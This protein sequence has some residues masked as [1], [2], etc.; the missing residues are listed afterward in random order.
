MYLQP[1]YSRGKASFSFIGS[2]L[3][4]DSVASVGEKRSHIMSFYLVKLE[5]E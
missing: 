2:E 5:M 3:L 4:Y 1:N